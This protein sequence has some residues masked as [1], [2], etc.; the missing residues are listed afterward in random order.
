MQGG[1]RV[2]ALSAAAA[3]S[4]CRRVHSLRVSLALSPGVCSY[5]RLRPGRRGRSRG[6]RSGVCSRSGRHAPAGSCP[7]TRGPPAPAPAHARA[8]VPRA[9]SR[10]LSGWVR[11]GGPSAHLRGHLASF[12]FSGCRSRPG[13]P[14]GLGEAW[15]VQKVTMPL[16]WALV[17]SLR[18]QAWVTRAGTLPQPCIHRSSGVWPGRALSGALAADPTC[19]VV[20]CSSLF[21]PSWRVCLPEE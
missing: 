5:S 4:R 15:D 10:C 6:R 20:F 2:P 8:W 12:A 7:L 9:V 13:L 3:G 18:S 19:A 11:S 21:C 16:P 17:S 14:P 1:S